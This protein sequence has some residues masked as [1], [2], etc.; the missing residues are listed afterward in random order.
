MNPKARNFKR[1]LLV[2]GMRPGVDYIS[3]YRFKHW[4]R[5]L[6]GRL[7]EVIDEVDY[8]SRLSWT[9]HHPLFPKVSCHAHKSRFNKQPIR[10]GDKSHRT[11]QITS[12]FVCGTN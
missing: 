1:M 5:P 6:A 9:N 7:A 10:D 11:L 2:R 3:E 4:I 12:L 8:S